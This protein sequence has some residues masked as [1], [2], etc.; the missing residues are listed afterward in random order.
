MWVSWV[1]KPSILSSFLIMNISK[2]R[3]EEALYTQGRYPE[4][5][6]FKNYKKLRNL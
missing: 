2:G 1:E 4:Q 5:A 3:V 6:K